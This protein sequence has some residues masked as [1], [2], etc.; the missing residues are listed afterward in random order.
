MGIVREQIDATG[1]M[2]I[3]SQEGCEVD[4]EFLLEDGSTPDP[5]PPTT[6]RLEVETG[7]SKALVVSSLSHVFKMT[8]T[9]TEGQAMR[10]AAIPTGQARPRSVKWAVVDNTPTVPQVLWEGLVEFEGW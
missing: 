8:I 9:K 3:H 7:L 1:T 6:L 4:W 10:T 5:T 2:R